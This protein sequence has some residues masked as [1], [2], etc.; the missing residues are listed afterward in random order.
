M[1]PPEIARIVRPFGMGK[2]S[3][4]RIH[5][6]PPSATARAIVS[7]CSAPALVN[8]STR[9]LYNTRARARAQAKPAPVPE[10]LDLK[11]FSGTDT[12]TGT[13]TNDRRNL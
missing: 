11:P 12:G 2:M 13:G 7:R 5:R 1:S 8:V 6:S 3:A 10:L 4:G 9:L